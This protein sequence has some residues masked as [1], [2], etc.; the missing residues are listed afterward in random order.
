MP[1]IWLRERGQ[2]QRRARGRAAEP[3]R[4]GAGPGLRKPR[5]CRQVGLSHGPP[6]PLTAPHGPPRPP[7]PSRPPP[8]PR[9]AALW[10]LP[11]LP[12]STASPS[13][14]PA[15]MDANKAVVRRASCRCCGWGGIR[16]SWPCPA[17]SWWGGEQHHRAGA[18]HPNPPQPIPSH[19]NSHQPTS[20]HP[21]TPQPT[22]TYPIPSQPTPTHPIPP[23][24]IPSYPNPSQNIPTH[25]STCQPIP[26]HPNSC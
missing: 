5:K 23:Q 7:G 22:P 13:R 16:H 14:D 18:T 24:P 19:P 9:T 15:Q 4:R 17:F 11:A 21:N 10:A 3:G 20:T 25:P 2:R 6:P 26:T 12:P 1:C 8:A